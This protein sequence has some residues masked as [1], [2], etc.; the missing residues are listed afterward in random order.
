MV[1]LCW[2]VVVCGYGDKKFMPGMAPPADSEMLLILRAVLCYSDEYTLLL[3][4]SD[5]CLV[6]VRPLTIVHAFYPLLTI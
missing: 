6:E 1:C 5:F 3:L 2:L 4:G